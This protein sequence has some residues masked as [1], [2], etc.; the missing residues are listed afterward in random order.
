LAEQKYRLLQS[1]DF[2]CK[3]AYLQEDGEAEHAVSVTRTN[4][5]NWSFHFEQEWPVRSGK[6]QFSLSVPTQFGKNEEGHR[7]V[8]DVELGSSEFGVQRYALCCL[9]FKYEKK[10]IPIEARGGG[11]RH[12]APC[13]SAGSGVDKRDSSCNERQKRSG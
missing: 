6:H 13:V 7:G 8:G 11:R 4:R 3:T 1:K 9:K 12:K 2:L 10:I 5:H